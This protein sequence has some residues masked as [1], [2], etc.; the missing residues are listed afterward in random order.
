M[1]CDALHGMEQF[2]NTIRPGDIEPTTPRSC[3]TPCSPPTRSSAFTV[4]STWRSLVPS[5]TWCPRSSRSPSSTRSWS[6]Q[7][8]AADGRRHDL[9]G[10]R[11]SL[12]CSM[13][14]TRSTG[15]C[16]FPLTVFR[17]FGSIFFMVGAA[18]IMVNI[19]LF[20]FNMFA[21]VLS[22]DRPEEVQHSASSCAPPLASR[23]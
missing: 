15:R 18:V 3:I 13:P 21:T 14:Y 23:G 2:L 4:L 11:A 6:H 16:R 5:I 9:L 20:S 10:S 7:L 17:L 19:L 12:V 1:T 8:L 22:S